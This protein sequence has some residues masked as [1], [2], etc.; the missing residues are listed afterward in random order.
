[1]GLEVFV[2]PLA[3]ERSAHKAPVGARYSQVKAVWGQ[4][5]VKDLARAVLA[6][7]CQQD[8]QTRGDNKQSHKDLPVLHPLGI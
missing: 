7:S 5:L 1:M 2:Q 4:L 3:R 8:A 6:A